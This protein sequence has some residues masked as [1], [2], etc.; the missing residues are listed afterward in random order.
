MTDLALTR[1]EALIDLVNHIKPT[2]TTHDL[3][4]LMAV[5]KGLQRIFNFH[6]FPLQGMPLTIELGGN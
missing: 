5:T 4:F 3:V 2:A 6:V 1:F